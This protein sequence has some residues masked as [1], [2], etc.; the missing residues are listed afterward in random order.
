[1]LEGLISLNAAARKSGIKYVTLKAAAQRYAESGGAKGLESVKP[2]GARDYVTTMQAVDNF[3][4][5][6]HRPRKQE[7]D[8]DQP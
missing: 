6:E 1:M 5:N 7:N 3:K 8:N 2:E 4:D